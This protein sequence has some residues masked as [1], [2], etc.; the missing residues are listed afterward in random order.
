MTQELRE[1]L[2]RGAWADSLRAFLLPD[3]RARVV[4]LGCGDGHLARLLAPARVMGFDADPAQ[5]QRAR[6]RSLPH[7][8]FDEGDAEAL[9]VGDGAFDL[10][11]CQALLVH[12]SRPSQ[13]LREMVRVV[14]PG[15]RIAAIEPLLPA[16]TRHPGPAVDD[17]ALFAAAST[18]AR[19]A[20]LGSWSIAA[21]LPALFLSSGVER[22]TVWRHPGVLAVPTNS[23]GTDQQRLLRGLTVA[24]EERA[25]DALHS[26]L[27]Q[28]AGCPAGVCHAALRAR[29]AL[30]RRRRDGLRAGT[31][32]EWREHPMVVCVGHPGAV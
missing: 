29:E 20:G 24:A 2:W 7:A 8:R 11:V 31:W 12:L 3:G 1:S 6:G 10:A 4:D 28:E 19:A 22:V 5:V 16:I 14:R 32:W 30:R 9:P 25:E 27:A 15:G 21:Q 18:G 17:A 26:R 23:R 13:V